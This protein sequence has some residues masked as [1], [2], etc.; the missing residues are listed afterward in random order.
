MSK[1]ILR[2]LA[3]AVLIVFFGAMIVYAVI[4]CLPTSYVETIARQR[5]SLPGGKS[6]TEWL[7]QLNAVYGLDKGIIPGFFGWLKNA[8]AGDFGESWQY[9]VP[10]TEK[11]GDVIW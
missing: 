6:Y 3:M 1:Y 9:N 7:T 5:A 4:R 11:F 8:L 10:V 2:R